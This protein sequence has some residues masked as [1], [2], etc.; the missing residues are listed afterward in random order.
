[1]K[2][3][4]LEA[5]SALELQQL[6][7]DAASVLAARCSATAPATEPRGQLLFT[8]GSNS[9]DRPQDSSAKAGV[10]GLFAPVPRGAAPLVGQPGF[11]DSVTVPAA[12]LGGQKL[13]GGS[14]AGLFGEASPNAP[15]VA[16]AAAGA[17]SGAALSAHESGSAAR[18]EGDEEEEEE[19]GDPAELVKEQELT[20]VPGWSPSITLQMLESMETGEEEEERL[21]S[22]RSKLY[23]FRGGEWKERGIGEARLLKHKASGHVRFLLRQEKTEKVMANHYVVD[24]HPLCDLRPNASSDKIWNWLAQDV[25]D[26]AVCLESFGL[27]FG[28]AEIAAKFKEA[29]EDAKCQN[30]KALSSAGAAQNDA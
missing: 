1:M 8:F 26:G 21:Y 20:A 2:R 30:A 12:P 9:L 4:E 11:F 15:L 23:R 19:G 10:G 5:L 18:K 22:Q 7:S 24:H 28:S 17:G 25:S 3:A 14:G 27:K 16:A 13:F 29:F 6:I